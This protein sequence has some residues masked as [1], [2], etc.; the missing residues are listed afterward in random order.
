MA[1]QLG[2]IVG[3][4]KDESGNKGYRVLLA[5]IDKKADKQYN[6]SFQCMLI[7]ENRINQTKVSNWLNIKIENGKIKGSSGSLSRFEDDKHKP[8]VIISQLV[9]NDNKI[10]GYKVASYDGT[11]KN[12]HIKEML[13][14]GNRITKM[15][16]IPV[17]NAI[18]VPA[19]EDKKE[20]FK[21]YPNCPFI[22]E[23]IPSHKN[24]NAEAKRVSLQ[25]NE[26]TLSKLEEIYSREQLVQLKLGKEHGVDIRVYANPALKPN[27]MTVLREG[28]EKKLNVKLFAFPEYDYYVMRYYEDCLENN[29]DIRQFLSPKYNIGQI[30]ELSLAVEMGLDIRKMCNPKLKADEMAEIRE[31]LERNIWK[32]ELVK[33]DG[34]WK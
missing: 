31:R 16:C 4:D 3:I 14:Y 7:P 12:I 27:Q 15:G 6:W 1:K 13:A 2:I 17:Q 8:F 19:D 18:F 11:V 24:K 21:S 30:S 10:L 25:K 5:T 22:I 33:K 23:L 28:L 9:N 32:D 29:I 26:K 20:H 34:S